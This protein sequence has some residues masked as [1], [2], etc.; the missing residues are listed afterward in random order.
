M[1][2][3]CADL[4][5][6]QDAQAWPRYQENL[7][8]KSCPY[9]G[10]HVAVPTLGEQLPLGAPNTSGGLPDHRPKGPWGPR[11]GALGLGVA[12]VEASMNAIGS[13]PTRATIAQRRLVASARVPSAGASRPPALMAKPRVT[14]EEVPTR[15][16]R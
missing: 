15:V 1:R 10:A 13:S 12:E 8:A 16:G 5:R 11:G 2:W 4:S 7:C 9:S 6:S 14:P 3:C